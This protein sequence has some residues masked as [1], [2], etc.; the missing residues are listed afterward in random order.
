MSRRRKA[1]HNHRAVQ[2]HNGG[3]DDVSSSPCHPPRHCNATKLTFPKY[4]LFSGRYLAI[5][6]IQSTANK[7]ACQII[8]QQALKLY[9]LSYIRMSAFHHAQ[10]RQHRKEVARAENSEL[11]WSCYLYATANKFK[12]LFISSDDSR[13]GDRFRFAVEEN[14]VAT[15]LE[16]ELKSLH[17]GESP[18][19]AGTKPLPELILIRCVLLG[20]RKTPHDLPFRESRPSAG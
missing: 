10:P 2:R 4:A 19:L 14:L 20:L 11:F 8:I 13:T 5:C 17:R 1:M 12:C 3:N 7:K 18:S 15:P 6:I 16:C 9:S